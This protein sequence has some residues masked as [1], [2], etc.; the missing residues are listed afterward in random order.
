MSSEISLLIALTCFGLCMSFYVYLKKRNAQIKLYKKLLLYKPQELVSKDD[1]DA[2][3]FIKQNRNQVESRLGE[4]LSKKNILPKFIKIFIENKNV[5]Y[6][7]MIPLFVL[8]WIILTILI[9]IIIKINIMLSVMGG[10]I[11]CIILSY[12]GLDHM[13][14]RQERKFLKIFPHALDIIARGLKAGITI[15]KTFSTIIREIDEPVKGEFQYILDQINF[16]ISFEQAL[17]NTANHIPYSGFHFFV[18]VLILQKKT[19]GSA[20][21]LVAEM[22]HV[23]RT[24]E[25]LRGKIQS[26][27]AEAKT[28]GWIIGALP[29]L[30]FAGINFMRPEYLEVFQNTVLGQK[31]LMLAI[32]L[33]IASIVSIKKLVK[34]KEY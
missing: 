14:T 34:F 4:F 27:S 8:L 10:C 28:T 5:N 11:G 33:L 22:A 21:D 29:V 32:G 16:G 12:Y 30:A 3:L 25:E 20:A 2:F 24:Q 9:L 18:S 13:N 1:K 15:E 19:G 7:K 6:F 31:L 26:L 23:F 17:R